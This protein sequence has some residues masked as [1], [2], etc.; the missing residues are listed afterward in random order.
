MPVPRQSCLAALAAEGD[1]GD[2]DRYAS[3]YTR[4]VPVTGEPRPGADPL[5]GAA[6]STGP[7]PLDGARVGEARITAGVGIAGGALLVGLGLI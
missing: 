1:T 3:V 5:R 6:L 7:G 2:P 4:P